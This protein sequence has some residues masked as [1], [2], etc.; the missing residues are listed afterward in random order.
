M[1][2]V[3]A[4]LAPLE[5]EE[6]CAKKCKLQKGLSK[7]R[8]ADAIMIINCCLAT[9]CNVGIVSAGTDMFAGILYFAS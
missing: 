1:N 7:R 2:D 9:A 4:M 6:K 8:S 3:F 5:D